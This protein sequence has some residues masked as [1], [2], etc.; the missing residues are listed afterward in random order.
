M[1]PENPVQR[2]QQ[3][4]FGYLVRKVSIITT[5]EELFKTH[6]ERSSYIG[7]ARREPFKEVISIRF[8]QN[9]PQGEN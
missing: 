9:L 1:E 5:T 4:N 6:T 3:W 2:G 7:D 8:D